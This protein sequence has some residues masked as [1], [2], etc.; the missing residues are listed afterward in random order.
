M[1]KK[2][3]VQKQLKKERLA[4]K[5]YA[6]RMQLK[7]VISNPLTDEDERAKAVDALNK[8]P[9][10]SSTV[11][12]RNRCLLTGRCRGYLRKFGVSRIKFR[13]LANEGRI[14]G[15]FKASW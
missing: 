7:G 2:S 6:V 3:S 14:P 1:A 10:N 15:V 11:R 12:L 8:L 5:F 4:A 13:E 9:R